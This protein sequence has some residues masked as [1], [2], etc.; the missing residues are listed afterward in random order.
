MTRTQAWI[1]TDGA[2]GNERQA[3]ALATRLGLEAQTLCLHV[4]P[5]WSWFAPHLI[6]GGR[7]AWPAAARAQLQAP[8]PDI[9][10]GCGRSAALATHIIGHLAKRHCYTIQILDPRINPRH[11]DCVITPQHDRLYGPNVL[12]LLG[13]L[14]P[15]DT[16]WLTAAR[17]AW[18]ELSTLPSPRIAVLLGGPRRG[19][20][21]DKLWQ[22]ALCTGL[23]TRLQRDGGSLLISASRR[24]PAGLVEAIAEA[25][26]GFPLYIWRGSQDGSNPYPGFLAWSN[27]LVVSPDSVNMLSE[28]AATGV[29]VHTLITTPLPNKLAQFHQA[30]AQRGLLRPLQAE[31]IAPLQPLRETERIAT[32]VAEKL[33]SRHTAQKTGA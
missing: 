23:R 24:T 3:L 17:A 6:P 13:S 9:A 10:I 29:P 33:R 18:I 21:L 20:P 8:W 14:H 28:A 7:L 31:S 26:V 32:L 2:A 4:R 30:L 25:G 15:I 11:W 27:L 1:L 16:A 22:Q 12:S 19:I 5:P